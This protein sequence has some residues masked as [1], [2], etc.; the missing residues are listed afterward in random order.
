VHLLGDSSGMIWV[1]CYDNGLLYMQIPRGEAELKRIYGGYNILYSSPGSRNFISHYCQ[2]RFSSHVCGVRAFLELPSAGA[3]RWCVGEQQLDHLNVPVL[4]GPVQW[5]LSVLTGRVHIGPLLE[6]QLNDVDVPVLR[7]MTGAYV[8]VGLYPHYLAQIALT[9]L[10][11]K[12][13]S[14]RHTLQHTREYPFFVRK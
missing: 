6:Q 12:G 8:D 5:R 1:L 2:P 14:H 4:K 3:A 9:Q 7:P 11:R 13:V 10:G